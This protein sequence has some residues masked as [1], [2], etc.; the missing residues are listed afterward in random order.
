MSLQS[1]FTILF[2]LIIV[3][4]HI[5]IACKSQNFTSEDVEISLLTCS[6]GDELYSAYGHSAV[7]LKDSKLGLDVVFNYGTFDFDTPFFYLKF[8]NGTLDYML[9]TASYS[10]FISSYSREGRGVEESKL[11][12]SIS[13]KEQIE[14]LLL[15]NAQPQNRSYRYDF[16]FDNCATRI[17]DIVFKVADIDVEKIKSN[18][19]GVTYRD[20]LHEKVGPNEWSG[21]GIDIIL[22]VRADECVSAYEKAL[23]P[24]C[25]N[26]LFKDVSLTA[27][28]R[29][30]LT[31][32][33]KETQPAV[34]TPTLCASLFLV[35]IVILSLIE[36]FSRRWFRWF[37]IMLAVIC[38]LLAVLLWYLWVVSEIRITD[39]N[40]N[41][42]WASVLYVPL[43]FAFARRKAKMLKVLS[44]INLLSVAIFLVATLLGVQYASAP[45]V[46]ISVALAIRN[47]TYLRR[48]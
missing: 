32:R 27:S 2:A 33:V 6:S 1:K 44:S 29:P 19:E 35:V 10:R 23:L 14:R 38:S 40:M 46:L 41:V 17:R 34:L 26:Q 11:I 15:E 43:L 30:I 5:S 21:F 3:N 18:V 12:L 16:F 31:K 7:R 42:L 48:I 20:C 28:S 45:I 9:S 25:L 37:D 24:D 22:G 13:Q 39:Y 8:L 4:L 47:L 36:V